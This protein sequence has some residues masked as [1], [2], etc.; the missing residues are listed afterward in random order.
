M[1]AGSLSS[2]MAR[3]RAALVCVV[4]F[5]SCGSD[6][7]DA[8]PRA[9]GI[10]VQP[11]L[12]DRM[13]SHSDCEL[14][15]RKADDIYAAAGGLR[16]FRADLWKSQLFASLDEE[17]GKEQTPEGLKDIRYTPSYAT[18]VEIGPEGPTLSF[19]MEDVLYVWPHLIA[20]MLEQLRDRLLE[21]GVRRAEIGWRSDTG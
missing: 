19:D 9:Q 16:A 6:N 2:V 10:S 14:V 21:A 17:F 8:S 20:P 11:G 13:R 18:E 7:R 15:V 5:S 3:G 12:Q 4:L 1:P